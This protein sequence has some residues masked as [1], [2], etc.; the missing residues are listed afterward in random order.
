[1]VIASARSRIV[2]ANAAILEAAD[3]PVVVLELVE[4]A[5]AIAAVGHDIPTAAAENTDNVELFAQRLVDTAARREFRPV[6]VTAKTG[7]L[8]RRV[9]ED[10]RMRALHIVDG[11]V[12]NAAADGRRD[13]RTVIDRLPDGLRNIAVT[14]VT[15]VTIVVLFL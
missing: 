5:E 10:T 13:P 15:T 12:G 1:M 6:R 14:V 3:H 4:D 11:V 7:E 9:G 2:G 8:G